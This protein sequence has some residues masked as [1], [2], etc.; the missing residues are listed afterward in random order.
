MKALPLG[1]YISR[2]TPLHSLDARIKLILLLGVT[3]ALFI[4]HT[5]YG[6]GCAGAVLICLI[7]ISGVSAQSV[8][9]ALRPAAVVLVLSL[10]GN[11]FVLSQADI[12]FA[13]M[14]GLSSGLTLRTHRCYAH[15][16]FGRL[17]VSNMFYNNINS[18]CG[19]GIVTP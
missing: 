1:S 9:R 11:A 10:L 5:W 17:F 8:V 6:L 18:S 13:G 3:I 7:A 19:S 4:C 12:A 16:Y 14:A 15:H 2:Q